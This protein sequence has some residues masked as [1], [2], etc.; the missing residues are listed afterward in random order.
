MWDAIFYWTCCRFVEQFAA[1][2]SQFYSLL[3][4]KKTINNAHVNLFTR[5]WSLICLF[6]LQLCIVIVSFLP[7]AICIIMWCVS[8]LWPFIANKSILVVMKVRRTDR[9]TTRFLWR[10][11]SQ[12]ATTKSL[13][14]RT[15]RGWTTVVKVTRTSAVH[16]YHAPITLQVMS[17]VTTTMQNCTNTGPPNGP[18]LLCSLMVS[19]G[20]C[21]LLSLYVVCRRF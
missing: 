3:L 5:Y 13:V 15:T 21:R 6:S 17:V 2:D 4:F 20:V 19:V 16:L 7:T 9:N 1:L 12:S 8:G 18:V 14:H 11:C 10:N